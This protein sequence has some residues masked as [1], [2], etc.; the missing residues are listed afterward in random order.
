MATNDS[1]PRFITRD[2]PYYITVLSA[3]ELQTL[4][5]GRILKLEVDTQRLFPLGIGVDSGG[6]FFVVIIWATGQQLRKQL[7]FCP[8]NFHINL[9]TANEDHGIEDKGIQSLLPGQFPSI[10]SPDMLDHLTFTL[11]VFGHFQQALPFCLQ[12]IQID[13]GSHKG[14]LRYADT[15]LRVKRYKQ[16]MLTYAC[17]FQRTDEPRVHA[18]CV[19]KMIEC[20]MSSEWGC[21]FIEAEMSDVPHEIRRLLLMP[22]TI[23][24]RTNLS[25]ITTIP[26]F[27]LESRER[28]YLPIQAQTLAEPMFRGL[29]RFFRWLVPFYFAIMSTPREESDIAALTSPHISIRHILTLT[30]ETPLP[31]RWF[32]GEKIKHT[33]LPIPNYYP[34]TIEQI[35]LIMRIFE[36]EDNLPL[37]V[38]CGGGKGR[39]GTVA[40]CYLVAY[41]FG[42]RRD[43]LTQPSMSA[44]EAISALRAIRPGSI[45]TP[46]QEAFVFKWCSTIWKRQCV[47]PPL[48]PEPRPCSLEIEGELQPENDLFILVGL[49]GSGK[50]WFS[51]A[52]IARNMK[53]WSHISQDESGSR[54]FSEGQ[55]GRVSGR[56]LLD[57]CN[58][59]S[60]DRKK[61]LKLASQ[62]MSPVCIWFDYDSDLCISRAQNRANHPTLPPGNRVRQAVEQMRKEF[63]RPSFEEGFKAIVTVRSFSASR[64][65]VLLLSPPVVLFKYPR[66]PHLLNLG[67]ATDDDIVSDSSIPFTN[68][69][70][71]ITEKVRFYK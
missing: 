54:S 63:V 15:A 27:C 5:E 66:T 25:N 48:L 2:S 55:I 26:K 24:L 36:G 53:G 10:L 43:A 19:K 39:A 13:P 46:Q 61:W 31:E 42:K 68:G 6:E 51:N 30:E 57:R 69:H 32:S 50:S 34:P 11:F 35:D 28:L 29:P 49:P 60:D 45:E 20:S 59:A 22:W 21:I 1:V 17:A 47:V 37:L 65:L 14:F 8:K 67:A 58:T 70:V 38:H 16:S 56:I 3:T 18:Y 64:E 52:L 41:G 4:D 62:A 33:H 44:N 23:D 12:S 71:S 7:G 9:S 40:A